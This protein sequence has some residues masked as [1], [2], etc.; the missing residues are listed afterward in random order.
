MRV[1]TALG[2]NALLQRK[3]RPDADI[4]EHHVLAAARGLVPIAETNDLVVTHGNGP[5]V[6]VLALESQSDP[7]L[8][9]PYPLDV[10]GAQ[11]QGMIG[12][13][14][15]QALGNALPD[16][17]VVG[18][19]SQ[20]VVAA[21]DPAWHEPTKFVG[22]VY[23]EAHA[24]QL[25]EGRDWVLRPDEGDWRRVVASPQPLELVELKEI[26]ALLALGAIVVCAGGGGIPVVRDADGTLRGVE[27]VI[28]KDLAAA[29]LAEQIGA[30]ALVDPDRRHSRR[31]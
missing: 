18:L 26:R 27:A 31:G 4:Q 9:R 13:W 24:R 7:T 19:L 21:D 25:A 20:T 5:Q 14:L 2:G 12:Y 17:E 15:V 30:D 11:T 6:G 8:S 29:L 3:E 23:D 1:V 22:Q 28:D 16:R 10:L